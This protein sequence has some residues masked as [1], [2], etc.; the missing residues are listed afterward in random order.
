MSYDLRDIK[1]VRMISVG[2][3]L[4]MKLGFR[5]EDLYGECPF[6]LPDD[7]SHEPLSL[8]FNRDSNTFR[9][10]SCG[11]TGGVLDLVCQ[12]AHIGP[13]E[14]IEWIGEN[15]CLPGVSVGAVKTA[16]LL[17]EQRSETVA[18]PKAGPPT[19]TEAYSDFL[20]LLGEPSAETVEYM[21]SRYIT[22]DTLIRHRITDIKGYHGTSNFLKDK[23]PP[24]LLR[25]AGLFDATGRLWFESYPLILPYIRDS[26][27]A[28]LQ[29]HC[30]DSDKSPRYLRPR[31]AAPFLYNIDVL[32][33]LADADQVFLVEGIIDCLTLE[34]RGYHAVATPSISNFKPEWVN[35]F[36][37]LETYLVHSGEEAAERA[38]SAIAVVFAKADLAVRAIVLPR[39]H[40]VNS[41]FA[42]GGTQPEFEHLVQTAPRLKTPRRILVPESRG[43][44]AEF[45]EE[46][47]QH[48]RRTKPS[49]RNFL[50]LDMGF[51]V[52]TQV[53]GGLDPLGSGQ[54]CIV[55]GPPGV[56]KT[57]FCLQIAWQ[58]LESNEIAVLYI[59]Y[60][61][62][63]FVLRLK[64]LCQISKMGANSVLRGEVP[65]DR[66]AAAVEEMS[67]WGKGFFV[68]EGGRD[69]TIDVIRDCCERTRSITGEERV[70]TVVAH[71][72]AIPSPDQSLRGSDK[73]GAC[74]SELRLLSRQLAIPILLVSSTANSWAS[75]RWQD[76]TSRCVDYRED[77]FI[78]LEP[79][80]E[81]TK[82]VFLE[83]EGVVVKVDITKNRCGGVGAVSFDFLPECHYFSE[84]GRAVSSS[85]SKPEV[86][87]HENK[88]A[89]E[90]SVPK[91]GLPARKS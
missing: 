79:D 82:Q 78:L 38:A 80:S 1:N 75:S 87:L 19:L 14:A 3:K 50:G 65:A 69:T 36:R 12:V 62:P 30:M 21:Q 54:V 88:Q 47:R 74:A 86:E 91:P 46:L 2:K 34:D 83:H 64:T 6:R 61:E 72:E 55:T 77:M 84:R 45:L 60:D 85:S 24:E 59:S 31:E 25:Q 13:S 90:A 51:P 66:L 70:V 4:G 9:C 17:G 67:K 41:F 73:I 57:T 32:H 33:T 53:C 27:V 48:E 40:D 5:G 43:A 22:P 15:F 8:V 37:G 20:Q 49:G 44:T 28:F 29:A 52:L 68:V 10:L 16:S 71:L 63:K 11:N 76:S 23:Y 7:E 56:G 42:E 81:A 58:L 35:D 26:K 89:S 18:K 39:G